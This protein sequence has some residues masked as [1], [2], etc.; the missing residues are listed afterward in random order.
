MQMHTHSHTQIWILLLIPLKRDGGSI[1]G[2]ILISCKWEL[3]F[4]SGDL[5]IQS[6][7]LWWGGREATA[8]LYA[9]SIE[10]LKMFFVCI[11]VKIIVILTSL[12]FF[13][14]KI[15]SLDANN[16][17]VTSWI[18]SSLFSIS[19]ASW[20]GCVLFFWVISCPPFT[21]AQATQIS[22]FLSISGGLRVVL[23]L[24]PAFLHASPLTV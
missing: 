17:L 20:P 23:D 4:H 7:F 14:Q 19:S 6:P 2:L 8:S 21:Q 9:K 15:T 22:Q 1:G 13:S 16:N 5:C 24:S 3:V 12:K 18:T 10:F 11:A